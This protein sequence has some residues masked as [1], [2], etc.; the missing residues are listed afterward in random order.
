MKKMKIC[1][2]ARPSFDVYSTELYKGLLAKDPS[3]IGIFITTNKKE[4]N[5]VANYI[6]GFKGNKIYEVSDFLRNHW[7]EFSLELLCE[8]EKKY[9]CAPI[10]KYIY[11]DR[12]LIH[13]D[14]DYCVK[15]AAGLF[16]F[17]NT[18]LPQNGLIFITPNAYLHCSV[19]LDTLWGKK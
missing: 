15:I 16:S 12:F 13:R 2:L 3:M 19:T 4:T 6:K 1:F 9:Q 18:F 7:K 10:W 14:Y 5:N 11:T 8:Y 17:L